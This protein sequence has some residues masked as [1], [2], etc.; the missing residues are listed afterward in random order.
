[1]TPIMRPGDSA[2]IVKVAWFGFSGTKSIMGDPSAA[3]PRSR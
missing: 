3:K 1:M 2:L